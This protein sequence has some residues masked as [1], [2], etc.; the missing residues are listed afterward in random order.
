[1]NN[2]LDSKPTDK[3]PWI[4]LHDWHTFKGQFPETNKLSS[5]DIYRDIGCDTLQFGNLMVNCDPVKYPSKKVSPLIKSIAKTDDLG[6][7]VII[8]KTPWG[9]LVS[10]QVNG[11]PVKY[12]VETIEDVRILT[13]IWQETKYVTD[14]K[15]CRESYDRMD[16]YIGD[17]GIATPIEKLYMIRDYMLEIQPKG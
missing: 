17:D 10:A 15:G 13:R 2:I 5:F 4:N 8:R 6:R 16:E 14:E 11:H 3:I 1:M 12:P 9:T 7:D